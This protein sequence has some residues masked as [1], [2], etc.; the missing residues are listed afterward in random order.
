MIAQTFPKLLALVS[1]PDGQRVQC[2]VEMILSSYQL[3]PMYQAKAIEGHPFDGQR[4][5][6]VPFS[7]L[8]LISKAGS[9]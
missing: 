5:V 3:M 1:T 6:I 8:V 7:R 9:Q 4:K 2:E